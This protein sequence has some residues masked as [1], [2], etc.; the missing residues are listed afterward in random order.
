M[1]A[2]RRDAHVVEICVAVIFAFN[3][4]HQYEYG[5]YNVYIYLQD[6]HN[7]FLRWF[8]IYLSKYNII[9]HRSRTNEQTNVRYRST[10]NKI[11]TTTKQ[12][13]LYIVD[14]Y[15]KLKIC[16]AIKHINPI[17][18]KSMYNAWTQHTHYLQYLV[19]HHEISARKPPVRRQSRC[20]GYHHQSNARTVKSFITKCFWLK[21]VIRIVRHPWPQ[22]MPP[23]SFWMSWNVGPSIKSGYWLEL[24]LVMDQERFQ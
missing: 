19:H 9:H 6:T 3:S 16:D 13:Y 14:F 15:I 18:S 20:L 22:W 10:T 8:L 4:L 21:M 11:W 1:K 2:N 12:N 7:Y 17:K 23:A 5:I 24:A